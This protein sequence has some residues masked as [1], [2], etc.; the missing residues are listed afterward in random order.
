M[1]VA[2]RSV[3]ID[4]VRAG[5]TSEVTIESR[6]RVGTLK[7]SAPFGSGVLIFDTLIQNPKKTHKLII[8]L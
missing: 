2:I 8:A 1:A 5:E 6:C 3:W 4:L 7:G